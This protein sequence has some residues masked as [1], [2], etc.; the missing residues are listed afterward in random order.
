METG[1]SSNL[2]C[3]SAPRCDRLLGA[4]CPLQEQGLPASKRDDNISTGGC[5]L[6]IKAV[7]QCSVS[8]KMSPCICAI[9]NEYLSPLVSTHRRGRDSA[10]FL[11]LSQLSPGLSFP[12]DPQDVYLRRLSTCLAS[13][14]TLSLEF[15][16]PPL[17]TSP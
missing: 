9:S 7:T 1:L 17:H 6:L 11:G 12:V 8:S 2:P 14:R 16:E 10:L 3:G 15:P 4:W 13:S 5:D